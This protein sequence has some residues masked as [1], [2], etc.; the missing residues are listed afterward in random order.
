[1]TN[2]LDNGDSVR[3]LD[4]RKAELS[5]SAV[6]GGETWYTEPPK[7]MQH[8]RGVSTTLPPI[9]ESVFP[10]L[11]SPLSVLRL[12]RRIDTSYTPISRVLYNFKA[13]SFVNCN[14]VDRLPYFNSSSRFRYE[15]PYLR[16]KLIL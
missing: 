4:N 5:R 12:D 15:L 10:P 6:V 11:Y 7:S 13:I 1:M 14:L 16:A 8:S 3:Q 2:H 9:F